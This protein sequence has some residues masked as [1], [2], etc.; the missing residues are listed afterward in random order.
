MPKT[1][2]VV[3]PRLAILAGG[4]FVALNLIRAAQEAGHRVILASDH[5]ALADVERVYGREYLEAFQKLS[6]WIVL[7]E[8]KP[9]L[10]R[11]KTLQVIPYSRRLRRFLLS[12]IENE[13]IDTMFSTQS[14]VLIAPAFRT[15][16]FCWGSTKDLFTY[17]YAVY[18]ERKG[19]GIFKKFYNGALRLLLWVMLPR[20][21]VSLIF[22]G[23][24]LIAEELSNTGHD[25]I[26]FFPPVQRIFK[27][28]E[29]VLQVVQASRLDP[30]KNLERFLDVARAIPMVQFVLICRQ[31]GLEKRDYAEKIIATLP[32]N[33]Q[34]VS[35]PL[36]EVPHY[37]EESKVFLYT[38]RELGIGLTMIEA[39]TAG[40]FPL[41]PTGT[42]NGS[43]LAKLGV[44]TC[45]SDESLVED[46]R[47]AL[48]SDAG[49]ERFVSSVQEF[50]PEAFREWITGF[51]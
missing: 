30:G 4:E 23:S 11:L 43:V 50:S 18:R 47:K 19:K 5:V 3:H 28:R 33:V 15:Y 38:G 8:F 22:A 26:S 39:M 21:R 10:S 14:S 20:P 6:R 1:I 41:A 2:L 24:D 46:V 9:L 7:P 12:Q 13:S 29:K 34:L 37:Y 27:P 35:R 44:G 40:C 32:S 48:A 51:F 42:G 25:A 49:A 31:S 16:H 36:R 45:Y 17:P